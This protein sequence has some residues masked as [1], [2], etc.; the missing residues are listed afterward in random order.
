MERTLLGRLGTLS[1]RFPWIVV[2]A[3]LVAVVALGAF[4]GGLPSR[5]VSGGFE[6]PGSQSLAVQHSLRDRFSQS[7]NGGGGATLVVVHHPR[8]TVD[9]PAF[10][11]GLESLTQR[12]R[13]VEGVGDVTSVLASGNPAL[14]SPDRHTTYL[15]A[16]LQGEQSA[17]ITTA[18]RIEHA[19]QA[20]TREASAALSGLDV[21]T[22]GLA[23]F[24]HQ[25]NEVAKEDLE[26][27]ELISF[28]ITLAVLVIAFGS[29]IAAGLPLMLAAV[30][31]VVTLGALFFLAGAVE[32]SIYVTNTA[33]V[34][35]IGVGIDYALF[36][37]TRFRDELRHG[38]SVDRAVAR[39]SATAGQAVVLSGITVIVALA[40]MFLV[41]VQAFSSMAIGSMAVVAVAV[42]AAI[43]LLPAMLR[44][45]GT[46]ID[47]LHIPTFGRRAAVSSLPT[48]SVAPNGEETESDG[49]WHR[50]A[51][52][53]MRRPWL[54]L[55]GSLVVL[56]AL[57]APF[58]VIRLGQPGPSM[59]PVD[60][61]P[62]RATERLA[63]AFGPGV[64]GPIEILVETPGGAGSMT[65]L[66]KIDRLT[67]ALQ[68]DPDVAQVIGLTSL[69]PGAD[70]GT[71]AA[72]YARGLAGLPP[73]AAPLTPILTGLA[74]W[75]RGA[76]ITRVTVIG[77]HAPDSSAA[78]WLVERIRA[79]I[80][81]GAALAGEA[82]VGG[83]TAANLDL[84]DRLIGRLPL[85]VG[86]VLAL[87]FALLVLA[88]RSLLLP[89][90]AVLMNLLSVGASYGLIVGLF[91]LG[92]GE[93][94]L[95]FTSPG[96]IAAFVPLFLFS[97]L[98]GL[99]MDYEVFLMSRMKEEFE[100]TGSNEIAVARGLEATARTI[101]SAA[102]IMVTVFAA[103]A[104]G[105]LVPFKE[106]GVGLAAAVFLDASLVRIILVPAAMR[107]MGNW[108]WWMPRALDR[109]L[110][111]IELE[112]SD[113]QRDGEVEVAPAV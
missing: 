75:D 48:S 94:A 41:Q 44:L 71:Y 31:L 103:F 77:K 99:S 68:A 28:P 105:R 16:S 101:T 10:R 8:L 56:L 18:G 34:I 42:L 2:G 35:G 100:R 80:L 12:V 102:L 67:R 98:F 46:R 52:A 90:K 23:A 72:V 6:V 97:I 32:M 91:Q 76:D 84:A 50:W 11:A 82:S 110:P 108:N 73:T 5:L 85:V 20:A 22:G 65:N 113:H 87:S 109:W 19:A 51:V 45:V 9:D 62:R 112:R 33:S 13:A 111:R 79:D 37:V 55:I 78:E 24:F 17:Q 57:A 88:F 70:L 64:T 66:V 81:P 25:F 36:I 43:T 4:A 61:S 3:W 107:L 58:S 104:A 15:V 92:W 96:N 54:S 7:A 59:L 49:F 95:G 106:M 14:I 86:C 27:A 29:L 38:Y 69:I 89:L 74:N 26:R 47:R 93:R 40:G 39:A 83:A 21:T 1:A 60:A 63:E 53:V 30:S